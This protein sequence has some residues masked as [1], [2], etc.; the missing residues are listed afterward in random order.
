MRS[1]TIRLGFATSRKPCR[2]V[3]QQ[4]YYSTTPHIFIHRDF[5]L[6]SRVLQLPHKTLLGYAI[7]ADAKHLQEKR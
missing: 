7:S 2:I 6:R 5:T 3:G 4:L 1:L